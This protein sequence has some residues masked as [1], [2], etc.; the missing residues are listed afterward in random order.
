MSETKKPTTKKKVE[1][2][3]ET[4]DEMKATGKATNKIAKLSFQYNGKTHDK[5][6]E[7]LGLDEKSLKE[8]ESKGLVE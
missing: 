4:K 2:G 8:L 5:G 6:C 3:L 1:K 7:I